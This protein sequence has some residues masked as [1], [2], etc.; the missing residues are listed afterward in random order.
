MPSSPSRSRSR[1]ILRALRQCHPVELEIGCGK[2]GFLLRQAKAHPERNSSA[3]MG[4]QVLQVRRRSHGPLGH[5]QCSDHADRCKHFVI[6]RCRRRA[7]R[8]CTS[9]IRPWPKSGTTSGGSSRRISSTRPSASSTRRPTGRADRP[10]GVLRDPRGTFG[11]AAT[12]SDALRR[13]RI[14]R[15]R[16]ADG[17]QLRSEIP[18]RGTEDLPPR[19]LS[20]ALVNKLVAALFLTMIRAYQF[21]VRP[22]LAGGC[23]FVPTCSEYAVEAIERHGPWRG[24]RLVIKRILDAARACPGGFDPVP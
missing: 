21:A 10:R 11:S 16:R 13:R 9:T 15:S 2:G 18:P 6:L 8:R 14:R 3:S 19:I 4:Q 1:S 12:R 5:G 7:W 20:G 24:G 17:D 22:L 23:R